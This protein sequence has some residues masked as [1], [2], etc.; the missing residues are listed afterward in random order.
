MSK[1]SAMVQM[2]DDALLQSVALNSAPSLLGML[3]TSQR[4]QGLNMFI[5]LSQL[6]FQ[7]EDINTTLA[8]LGTIGG[9][10]LVP[11]IISVFLFFLVL[12]KSCIRDIELSNKVG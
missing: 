4:N 6:S 7:V 12:N 3:F 11:L 10:I 5:F 1:F 2:F 8:N 9:K